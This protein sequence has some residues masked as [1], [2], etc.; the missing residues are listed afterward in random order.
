M[1]F[2]SP[3]IVSWLQTLL[4]RCYNN[5]V[6]IVDVSKIYANS[7]PQKIGKIKNQ[8]IDTHCISW[9]FQILN[10]KFSWLEYKISFYSLN[11]SANVKIATQCFENFR[12]ANA[13]NPSHL[14]ARLRS[15]HISVLR[16]PSGDGHMQKS[17]AF[18]LCFSTGGEE[19]LSV[20]YFWLL[21][22][23]C[24]HTLGMVVSCLNVNETK[25]RPLWNIFLRIYW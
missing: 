20:G 4:H 2:L 1:L 13:P 6:F 19:K 12:G 21:N 17:T 16:K 18:N 15:I 8:S 10:I 5:T 9:D 3:R 7:L 14:V 22:K 23:F 24:H 11:A 25:F